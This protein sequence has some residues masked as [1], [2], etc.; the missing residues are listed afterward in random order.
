M[1]QKNKKIIFLISIFF[2]LAGCSS[3]N[4]KNTYVENCKS[5]FNP[6]S[7]TGKINNKLCE[8]IGKNLKFDKDG[9]YYES[10]EFE[11]MSVCE[12]K[13]GGIKKREKAMQKDMQD[14]LKQF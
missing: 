8:C 14:Y 5:Q 12:M 13:Y 11:T 1:Q 4:P 2:L 9:N 6:K 3:E 7:E 10:D